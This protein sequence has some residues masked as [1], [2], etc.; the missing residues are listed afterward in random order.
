MERLD[1]DAMTMTSSTGVRT[2]RDLVQ[3]VPFRNFSND[4]VMLAKEV[5]AELPRQVVEYHS[6]CRL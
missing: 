4:G 6:L 1:D 5:L 2:E 3:F